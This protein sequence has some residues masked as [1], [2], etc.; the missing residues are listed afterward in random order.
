MSNGLE[1]ESPF[2]IFMKSHRLTTLQIKLLLEKARYYHL[3]NQVRVMNQINYL[4]ISV[5]C[6]KRNANRK[7]EEQI[8][9]NPV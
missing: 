2:S 9:E 6:V 8:T 4:D 7:R 3:H 1:E 5:I